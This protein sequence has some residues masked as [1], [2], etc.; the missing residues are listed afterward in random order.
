MS[1]HCEEGMFRLAIEQ[2]YNAVLITTAQLEAPGPKIVYVNPAFCTQTGYSADELIGQT[3]RILQ[4]P[5]TDRAVLDRLRE[6]VARGDFFEGQTINYRKDGTPYLVRWNISPLRDAAGQISHYV[7]VQRD[8][9]ERMRTEQFNRQLLSSLGE[10]VFGLDTAGNLTFIN[11]TALTLLGHDD[12]NALLGRN[13]HELMHA[14]HPDGT[15][16]PETDC[17]I[18]EV[19]QTGTPLQAWRDIFFQADGQPLS[20]ESFASPI[21]DLTGEIA[22]GVVVFRDI[23]RQL[24]LEEKLEHAAHHDRLTGA[25]NRHFFDR[26]VEK[27]YHRCTRRDEPLSLVIVDI[28]HFKDINDQHGHLVGDEVLKQLVRHLSE[29]MRSSDVLTRWGGEEFALLLP[30]TSLEGAAAL[31]EMLRASVAEARL[32]EDFPQLTI[33]LGVT[34]LCPGGAIQEGFRRADEALFEAK[35]SGRNRVHVAEPSEADID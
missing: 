6:T 19:M 8:I 28:D 3:P 35:R 13:A 16:Y 1:S 26:L 10:G 32:G 2:A 7:S 11:Q 4:G 25:F 27:E 5:K 23:S 9:T 21:R 18:Y 24:A 22:G 12:E 17:P 14:H 30:D 20:V 34:R 33:S 15:P 31:A 29:R